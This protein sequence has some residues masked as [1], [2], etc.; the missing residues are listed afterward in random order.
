[1]SDGK[2]QKMIKEITKDATKRKITSHDVESKYGLN[3]SRAMS[4]LRAMCE[5]R[6]LT[7]EAERGEQDDRSRFYYSI[8]AHERIKKKGTF[9][10][11]VGL[12]SLAKDYAETIEG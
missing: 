1:M 10:K 11:G 4:I 7:R 9:K 3:R 6:I 2:Y 5:K 12:A 8:S